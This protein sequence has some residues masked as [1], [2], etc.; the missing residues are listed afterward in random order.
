MIEKLSLY[1][2]LIIEGMGGYDPRDPYTVAEVI[3]K[4]LNQAVKHDDDET[5]G[6]END[7]NYDTVQHDPESILN[8]IHFCTRKTNGKPHK[9]ILQL[10]EQGNAYLKF[11]EIDKEETVQNYNLVVIDEAHHIIR[12][13]DEIWENLYDYFNI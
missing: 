6:E 11:V 3:T 2:P 13:D 1:H 10:N 8:R 7:N 9:A 4:Q 12:E 5:K